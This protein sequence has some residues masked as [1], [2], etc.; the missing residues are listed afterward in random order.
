MCITCLAG[1]E[2][3]SEVHFR[4]SPHHHQES[5]AASGLERP[6]SDL[7]PSRVGPERVYR[8]WGIS[9]FTPAWGAV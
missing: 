1:S 9:S 3:T 2:V 6:W 7:R 8:L 5:T 4:C